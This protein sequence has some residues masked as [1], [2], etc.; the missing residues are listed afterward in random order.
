[1]SELTSTV[2]DMDA[3]VAVAAHHLL[4]TMSAVSGIAQLL[5]ERWDR[6]PAAERQ[7]LLARISV[8]AD[9]A[10]MVLLDLV[11]MLPPDPASYRNL[12][13]VADL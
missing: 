7:Q 6:V 8:A 3:H 9:S 5:E 11:R 4:G 13:L 2:T 12:R 1:M 10:A